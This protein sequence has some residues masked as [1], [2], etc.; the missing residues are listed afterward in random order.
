MYSVKISSYIHTLVCCLWQKF[1]IAEINEA[2]YSRGINRKQE[3]NGCTC[4]SCQGHHCENR[5]TQ[6]Q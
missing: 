1:F 5:G 2:Q 6:E 4:I 3:K